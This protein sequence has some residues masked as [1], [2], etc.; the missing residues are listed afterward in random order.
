MDAINREKTLKNWKKDW[1]WELIKGINPN[2]ID[3]APE[4]FTQEELYNNTKHHE[5]EKMLTKKHQ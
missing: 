5:T 2:L 4:W 1:K 3:L